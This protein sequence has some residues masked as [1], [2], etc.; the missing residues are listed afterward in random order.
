MVFNDKIEPPT[1]VLSDMVQAAGAKGILFPSMAQPGDP[2][3][4]FSMACCSPG[5]SWQ[6]MT[7]KVNF[8]RTS[9]PGGDPYAAIGGGRL[10][11]TQPRP[12]VQAV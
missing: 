6:S 10:E 9:R 2:T 5:I 11:T 8:Q 4:S 7:R 12:W 3:W 1:W